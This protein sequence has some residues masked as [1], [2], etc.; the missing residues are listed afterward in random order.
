MLNRLPW[1]CLL[2]LAL[3]IFAGF[4]RSAGAVT[5][6]DGDLVVVDAG[7][8]APPVAP[9]V[10][11]IDPVTGAQEV[12][13]SGGLLVAPA[14]I[15]IEATGMVLVS[16]SGAA[17][18]QGAVL[19]IDPTDG[20]QTV[21]SGS[22]QALLGLTIAPGSG[23]IFVTDTMQAA[24]LRVDPS[25]GT[26][27]PVSSGTLLH[28]PRAITAAPNGL[29][30]VADSSSA[31]S[32]ASS[33]VQIDPLTGAQSA[34]S[35]GSP[36]VGGLAASPGTLW[37]ADAT[38]HSIL[39]EDISTATSSPVSSGGDLVFPFALAVEYGGRLAVADW[40]DG[41]VEP[42][43]VRVNRTNGGQSIVSHGGYLIE[44]WGVAVVPEPSDW[45]LMLGCV[46]TLSWLRRSRAS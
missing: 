32:A 6:Q 43:I 17:T 16:D 33:V 18:G 38:G 35:S 30:Y 8:V 29:L 5:L 22:Y 45:I 40:G 20:A 1:I 4:G 11:R 13:S 28:F 36:S 14:A 9:S 15:A 27:S 21:L 23:A 31:G 46:A 24:V 19:R 25:T 7:R 34:F 2:P 42:A 39:R 3:L 37:L 41:A 26:P 12:V 44:P 10:I